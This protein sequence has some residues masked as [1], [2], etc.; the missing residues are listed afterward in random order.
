VTAGIY[1]AKAK[2]KTLLITKDFTGPLAKKSL[3]IEN[4][5]GIKKISGLKFLQKL[6]QHIRQQQIEI[7]LD[8]VVKIDKTSQGFVVLNQ[9]QKKF[10][11]KAVIIASGADS[12][13]LKIPGEKEFLGKGVNYCAICDA[14]LFKNKIVAVVG[15]GNTAFE[16][17]ITLSKWAK[18][19]YLMV[20]KEEIKAE[21]AIQ[22]KVKSI[23]KIKIIKPVLLKEIKG[24][25]VVSSIIYQNLTTEEIIELKVDGVFVAIGFVPATFFVKD[26]VDFSKLGE[27]I[28]NFHTGETKTPGLFAAGD[29]TNVFPKQIIVAAGEGAKTAVNAYKYLNKVKS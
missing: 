16:E 6:E 8:T 28:V 3:L 17:A 13:L 11:A 1:A 12:R 9:K 26:L 22:E 25:K 21:S 4:Y 19:V 7:K 20:Y 5:P 24:E 29:V 15:G 10:L 2:L 18:Q 27:I 23:K 14:S